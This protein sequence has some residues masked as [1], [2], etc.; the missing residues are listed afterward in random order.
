MHHLSTLSN[1]Y[2]IYTG[3]CVCTD[4]MFTANTTDATGRQWLKMFNSHILHSQLLYTE[5]KRHNNIFA[6]KVKVAG[7]WLHCSFIGGIILCF[8]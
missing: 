2:I 5:C 8:T 6:V 7:H 4:S 3:V 1:S